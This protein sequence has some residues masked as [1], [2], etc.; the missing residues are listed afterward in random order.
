MSE[1]PMPN[2]L[3]NGIPPAPANGSGGGGE[4]VTDLKREVEQL[5]A[6]LAKAT[7]EAETYRRAAYAMLEQLD[8]YVPPTEEE[9]QDMLHGPRGRPI[10]DIIAEFEKK[11]AG[12]RRA[13]DGR[14]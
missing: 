14:G 3:P 7:A 10:L 2:D 11:L 5:R 9:L 12:D 1:I 8:P 4:N 6:Q 13:A